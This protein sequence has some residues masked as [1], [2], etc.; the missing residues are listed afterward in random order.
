M[1]ILRSFA[2]VCRFS[3]ESEFSK[4]LK[5]TNLTNTLNNQFYVWTMKIW[6]WLHQMTFSCRIMKKHVSIEYEN[7]FMRFGWKCLF[8][9]QDGWVGLMEFNERKV[10][11]FCKNLLYVEKTSESGWEV[12]VFILRKIF[13]LEKLGWN[14]KT[15]PKSSFLSKISSKLS[16]L[17]SSH[18][19]QS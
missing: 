11:K 7:F 10:L 1:S 6:T 2:L 14:W 16:L 17:G 9:I 5:L 8:A 18:S 19:L 15:Q 13:S 12:W 4:N 3:C